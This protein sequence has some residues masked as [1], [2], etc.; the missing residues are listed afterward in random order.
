MGKEKRGRIETSPRKTE[1]LK[2]ETLTK[3][4]ET[5][6]VELVSG[7]APASASSMCPAPAH[8]TFIP[9]RTPT[10]DTST[11]KIYERI[12]APDHSE[13]RASQ[14]PRPNEKR[15]SS[16]VFECGVPPVP[17]RSGIPASAGLFEAFL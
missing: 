1:T 17:A 16:E 3:D 13:Q 9:S 6:M 15:G 11:I 2:F 7:Y 5:L 4:V 12:L 8:D 10:F 14:F